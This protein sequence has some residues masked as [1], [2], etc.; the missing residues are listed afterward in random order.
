MLALEIGKGCTGLVGGLAAAYGCYRAIRSRAVG[1][2]MVEV[3]DR[4]RCVL[5]PES[6]RDRFWSKVPLAVGM[7]MGLFSAVAGANYMI[8]AIRA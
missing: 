1:V 6:R 3:A 8:M 2:W 7:A 5:D 4:N